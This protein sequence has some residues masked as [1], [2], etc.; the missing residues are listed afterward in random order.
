M[1]KLKKNYERLW[2]NSSDFARVLGYKMIYKTP[3]GKFTNIDSYG[4]CSYMGERWGEEFGQ[5][6]VHCPYQRECE[7]KNAFIKKYPALATHGITCTCIKTDE[8]YDYENSIEKQNDLYLKTQNEWVKTKYGEYCL[9]MRYER[10]GTVSV[11]PNINICYKCWNEKCVV[12]GRKRDITK[13]NIMA[14][15]EYSVKTGFLTEQKICKGIKINKNPIPKCVADQIIKKPEACDF[16]STFIYNDEY[17][18]RRDGLPEVSKLRIYG[19]K[20]GAKRDILEDL[21]DIKEGKTV[22]HASDLIKKS[23]REKREKREK[24]IQKK[25]EKEDAKYE[26]DDS[27]QLKWDI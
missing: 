16:V 18:S 5:E 1:E 24:Y 6:T 12:S 3:C 21:A 17:S 2:K 4:E 8:P 10:Y 20:S 22:V 27:V 19:K 25:I 9:A 26:H 7:Y 13:T 11:N 14:D 15:K 23:K